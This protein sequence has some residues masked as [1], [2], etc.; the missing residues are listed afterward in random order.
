MNFGFAAELIKTAH[1][2]LIYVVY[3]GKSR[4]SEEM[5]LW[6]ER[7]NTHGRITKQ[8]KIIYQNLKLTQL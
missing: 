3:T 6:G 1:L 2:S 5:N 4:M 8:M 7:Q